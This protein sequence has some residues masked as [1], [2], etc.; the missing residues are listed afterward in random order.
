[1]QAEPDWFSALSAVTC[2]PVAIL[3]VCPQRETHVLQGR[4][5]L[6]GGDAQCLLGLCQ[7]FSS[8][9]WSEQLVGCALLWMANADRQSITVNLS[10]RTTNLFTLIYC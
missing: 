9:V 8:G 7:H 6:S 10:V 2:G 4:V 3:C 5:L 1:M